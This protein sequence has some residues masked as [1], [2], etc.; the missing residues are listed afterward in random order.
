MTLARRV[1]A[2]EATL[3]PTQAVLRWLQ[4][5]QAFPSTTEYARALASDPDAP[6]PLDRVV[7]SAQD[8]VRAAMKGKPR[9]ELEAALTRAARETLF[10]YLLVMRL[11]VDTHEVARLKGLLASSLFLMMR[12]LAS[13][14]LL[15]AALANAAEPRKDPHDQASGDRSA[16]DRWREL[17]I[18]LLGGVYAEEDA[19]LTLERQYLDGHGALFADVEQEWAVARE[20]AERIARFA[21]LF[22]AARSAS[23]TDEKS[24]E[25]PPLSLAS[26]T[27]DAIREGAAEEA[28][29]RASYVADMVRAQTLDMAGE[30]RRAA[31]I[32][33]QHLLADEADH[34]AAEIP[35]G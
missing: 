34:G 21:R 2:L 6:S 19:R 23:Q 16:W 10:R 30:H 5:A 1:A 27:L 8:G 12:A 22:E 28:A 31:S 15:A 25:D 17:A 20:Q 9:E 33:A 32:V 3:T 7:G 13:D 4:E 26:I 35:T 29:L 11:N 18:A 24:D 14:E